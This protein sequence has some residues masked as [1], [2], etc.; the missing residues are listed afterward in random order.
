MVTTEDILSLL[1]IL[2]LSIAIVYY[3][4]VVRN[5]NKARQAGLYMQLWNNFRNPEFLRSFNEVM[6]HYRWDDYEDYI[7]KYG[8]MNDIEAATKITSVFSL[9]ESLGGLLQ[10]GFLDLSVLE[11]QAAMAFPTLW[12]KF[13]PV[14]EEDRKAYDNPTLWDSAEYLY[15]ELK[16][17]RA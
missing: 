11:E 4:I 5:A 6:Y 3:A 7:A 12:E 13:K 16:K 9:F 1:P 14:I 8:V 17:K 15:N 10:Q 2:S